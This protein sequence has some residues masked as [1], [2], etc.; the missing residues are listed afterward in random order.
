MQ[1]ILS[2]MWE[3]KSMRPY[4]FDLNVSFV[5]PEELGNVCRFT[6]IYLCLTYLFKTTKHSPD[7]M[8]NIV[9]FMIFGFS[10]VF[11]L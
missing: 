10:G 11:I 2:K 7:V 3:T 6:S 1:L 9:H 8:S 5:N 4:S